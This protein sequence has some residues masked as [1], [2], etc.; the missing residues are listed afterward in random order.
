MTA[1][2]KRLVT[3]ILSFGLAGSLLYVALQGT[4][5]AQLGEA[6]KSASYIWTIPLLI[7]ILASHVMRAWRWQIL[8]EALPDQQ[9]KGDLKK[10]SMKTAFL[11]VMIGYFVNFVT[12]RLGE[13]V[14]AANMSRQESIRF[15][16]VLGT[17]VVERILDLAVLCIGLVSLSVLFSDQFIFFEREILAPALNRFPALS[18][19]WMIAGAG[20][21][22]AI[23]FLAI[24]TIHNS[25]SKPISK[26]RRRV[27]S[28]YH[29][30]RDGILTILRSPNRISLLGSTVIMWALYA[31]MAYLPLV[32]LN[33][34]TTY[35]M[36]FSSAWSLMIFGALGM[37]VP[38]PGGT[39]SYHVITKLAL[40]NLYVVDDASAVLYALL[41][42]GFPMIV[43]IVGGVLAFII[44][45][46][47]LKSLK[48]S[49][50]NL[51]ET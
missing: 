18:A 48:T 32:M 12:P 17:V 11:S 45:G 35:E 42:H 39:G 51:E 40:V 47:T 23:G 2:L 50:K 22:F 19:G 28:V 5:F 31:V 6:L 26:L 1:H 7:A 43:Y 13:F 46:V 44:Q 24:R 14:R 3:Y 27:I 21:I 38:S 20:S 36:G 49:A 30:F 29:A 25:Q 10:V 33:M 4:D 9:R 41:S 37:A 15:S 34:H 16:G 8:L